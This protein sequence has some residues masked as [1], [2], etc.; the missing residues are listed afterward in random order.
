MD[1]II[2]DYERIAGAG[3]RRKNI[4]INDEA[5]DNSDSS[6]S[7]DSMTRLHQRK[8]LRTKKKNKQSGELLNEL[9]NSSD[10]NENYTKAKNHYKNNSEYLKTLKTAHKLD[11]FCLLRSLLI[12]KAVA[13]KE[14]NWRKLKN[15]N[16]HRINKEVNYLKKQLHLPDSI[17]GLDLNYLKIISEHPYFQEYEIIIFS[18]GERE[19]GPEYVSPFREDCEKKIYIFFDR[20]AKHF[21]VLTSMTNYYGVNYYCHSCK[22]PYSKIGEHTCKKSCKS[23]M[24]QNCEEDPNYNKHQCN[25]CKCRPKNLECSKRHKEKACYVHHVCCLC[26]KNIRKNRVH[27]CLNQKWCS[28]CKQAVPIDHMC[29]ILTVDQQ[30]KKETEHENKKEEKYRKKKPKC[31]GLAIFDIESYVDDDSGD[32]NAFKIMCQKVNNCYL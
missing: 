7:D 6:S 15:D 9:L 3:L 24:R 27:V 11:N 5:I 23:C 26:H 13:D 28:N 16:N 1:F 32:H 4:F 18:S 31:N 10:I 19:R 14:I 8:T 30:E 29:F 21:Y 22:I 25:N 20:F 17:D 12:G 2:I